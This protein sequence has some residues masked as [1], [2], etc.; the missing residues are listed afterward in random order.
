LKGWA[1]L[2]DSCPMCVHTPLVRSRQGLMY[3]VCCEMEVTDLRPG[4]SDA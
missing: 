1:L 4:T 2:A 3:C